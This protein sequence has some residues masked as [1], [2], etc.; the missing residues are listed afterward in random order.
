VLVLVQDRCMVCTECTTGSEIVWTQTMELL[1]DAG[2][3]ESCFGLFRDCVS[4]GPFGD[5]ANLDTR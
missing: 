5:S 3:V 2:H 4:V 1:G